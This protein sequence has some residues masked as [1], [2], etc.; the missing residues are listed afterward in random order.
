MTPE[1]KFKEMSKMVGGVRKKYYVPKDA[2]KKILSLPT[3]EYEQQQAEMAEV[4][5]LRIH[6]K[7]AAEMKQKKRDDRKNKRQRGTD[8]DDGA[9]KPAAGGAAVA[10]LV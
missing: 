1:P 2:E 10:P 5:K 4:K 6:A 9:A 8:A 3:K 7:K